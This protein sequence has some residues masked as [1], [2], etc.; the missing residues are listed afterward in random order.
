MDRDEPLVRT[1][2]E[3]DSLGGDELLTGLTVL[4]IS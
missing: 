2:E 3:A 1:E 4:M